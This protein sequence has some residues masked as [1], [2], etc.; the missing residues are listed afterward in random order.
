M[1]V[2]VY[3]R[4]AVG[5]GVDRPADVAWLQQICGSGAVLRRVSAVRQPGHG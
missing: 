3:Y 1:S 5:N 2:V 4:G